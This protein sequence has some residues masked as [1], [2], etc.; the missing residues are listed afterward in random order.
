VPFAVRGF[1]AWSVW[2]RVHGLAFTPNVSPR[3]ESADF[4]AP[5]R[6]GREFVLYVAANA[7]AIPVAL[8]G[9]AIL[10]P[11]AP[12]GLWPLMVWP[13]VAVSAIWAF[14]RLRS[15]DRLWIRLKLERIA[16]RPSDEHLA[17]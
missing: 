4:P 13:V 5:N 17:G 3:V 7:I 6:A 10:G 8:I 15:D 11:I 2:S 14:R 1:I 9:E 16:E 12:G